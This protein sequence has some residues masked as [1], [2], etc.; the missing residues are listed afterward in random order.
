METEALQTVLTATQA[1]MEKAVNHTKEMFTRFRAGKASGSMLD[2]IKVDHYGNMVPL[3]QVA[4][5]NTPDARTI[6]I[7]PWEKG[8]VAPI[9]KA[10]IKSHLELTPQSDGEQVILN[11]P[12]L[13][14]EARTKLTKQVHHEAEHGRVAIRNIRQHANKAL[15]HLQKEG[16]DEDSVK[17]AEARV[18]KQTDAHIKTIEEQMAQKE[19][20]IMTV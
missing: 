7:K 2:G 8:M 11:I 17:R 13:T 18:Q 9:E 5:I 16:I 12:P 6:M 3:N 19:K 4:S 10:I 1:E 15:K 20:S 14:E